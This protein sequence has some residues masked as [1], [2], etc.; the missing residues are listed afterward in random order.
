MEDEIR[1]PIE[2]K[3]IVARLEPGRTAQ[4]KA[5]RS[6]LSETLDGGLGGIGENCDGILRQ[7]GGVDACH[8]IRFWRDRY[9]E[10]RVGSLS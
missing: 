1:L 3:D 10:K 8:A 2:T 5:C 4:D 7:T 6:E 9:V